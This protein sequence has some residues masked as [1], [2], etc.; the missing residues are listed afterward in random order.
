MKN[1]KN[2][3]FEQKAWLI[4]RGIVVLGILVALIQLNGHSSRLPYFGILIVVM[5]M[6]LRFTGLFAG[7]MRM[8]K[9]NESGA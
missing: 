5:G 2:T 7:L 6:A 4:G 1:K 9:I 8:L 3:K